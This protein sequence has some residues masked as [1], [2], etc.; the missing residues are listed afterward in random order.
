MFNEYDYDEDVMKEPVTSISVPLL[1]PP[2]V[3]SRMETSHQDALLFDL[4]KLIE[5]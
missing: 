3:S 2:V 1:T 4:Q 5:E